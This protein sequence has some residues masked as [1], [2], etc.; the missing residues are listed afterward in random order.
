VGEAGVVELAVGKAVVAAMVGEE[1]VGE[2]WSVGDALA[3]VV[4]GADVSVALA[5]ASAVAARVVGATVAEGVIV[6]VEVGAGIPMSAWGV[7]VAGL[8]LARKSTTIVG[9]H[10][11]TNLPHVRRAMDCTVL[12]GLP[13]CS[14]LAPVTWSDEPIVTYMRSICKKANHAQGAVGNRL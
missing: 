3:V 13:P 4:A 12:I 14:I 10:K 2:A 6:A 1:A 11:D 7:A 9:N 5:D 8:Q